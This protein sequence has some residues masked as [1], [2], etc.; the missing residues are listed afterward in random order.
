[1]FCGREREK[2]NH[3]VG[4]NRC[5]DVK[6]IHGCITRDKSK[7]EKRQRVIKN[8]GRNRCVMEIH[9]YPA[10]SKSKG[11]RVG[12]RARVKERN[13]EGSWYTHKEWRA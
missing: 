11:K 3:E 10:R 6:E 5:V 1:M 12:E 7:K 8:E 4:K 9:G 2:S 13:D